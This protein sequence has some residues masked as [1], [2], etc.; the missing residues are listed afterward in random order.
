MGDLKDHVRNKSR[1]EGSIAEGYIAEECL[2]FCS[3]YLED[4]DTRRTRPGRNADAEFRDFPGGFPI[5]LNIGH[6]LKGEGKLVNMDHK[7]WE[8]LNKY[9]LLNCP[10]VNPYLR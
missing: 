9:V 5:F 4:I 10:E 7:E 8:R 1:P 6:P 2:S 3:M